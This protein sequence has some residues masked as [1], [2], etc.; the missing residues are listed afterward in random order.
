MSASVQR[1]VLSN[2][3]GRSGR[4]YQLLSESLDRFA[5]APGH[6][7]LVALGA[8][9]M[10]VG[11][12]ADVIADPQ[13]RSRLRLAL[14]CGDRVFRCSDESGTAEHLTMVWDLEDAQPELALSAA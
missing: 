9:V 14:G 3:R 11:S 2:W 5:L 12:E 7:Y 1:Q 13:S 6:L 8:H 10:W 4:R